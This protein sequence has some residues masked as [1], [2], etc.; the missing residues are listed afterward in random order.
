MNFA[1]KTGFRKAIRPATPSISEQAQVTLGHMIRPGQDRAAMT[2]VASTNGSAQKT[3]RCRPESARG[4]L[5]T[6]EAGDSP[7]ND[8]VAPNTPHSDRRSKQPTA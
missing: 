3:H 6:R 7:N 1:R 2:A 5:T 4:G 8:L